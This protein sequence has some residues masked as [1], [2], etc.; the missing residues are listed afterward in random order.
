MTFVICQT[1][2][3]YD[4]EDDSDTLELNNQFR[5]LTR[6]Q[7]AEL[8]KFLSRKLDDESY[9]VLGGGSGDGDIS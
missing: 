7:L 3:L 4:R 1:A 2:S 5:S 8:D 9:L 6:Q